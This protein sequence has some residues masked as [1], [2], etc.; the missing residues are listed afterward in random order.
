MIG[1]SVSRTGRQRGIQHRKLFYSRQ[2][3]PLLRN[4]V[5]NHPLKAWSITKHHKAAE[6]RL[7]WVQIPALPLT[8]V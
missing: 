4:T 5:G 2:Q 7:H 3:P 8:S 6:V 1:Y